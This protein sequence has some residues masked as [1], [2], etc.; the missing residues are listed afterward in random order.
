[1]DKLYIKTDPVRLKQ[2]IINLLTNASKFTK[3]G[4]IL[5]SFSI[6]ETKRTITFSVTDTGIGIPKEK[7]E[8]IFERFVK[9]N[10]FAQGTGLGLALSR[11]IVGCMGGRIWVDTSYTGGACFKFTHPLNTAKP[12]EVKEVSAN[13]L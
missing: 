5:L 13:D 8:Y 6:D 4:H 12:E 2:V 10:Q 1:M 7:A 11:I 3:K 9:L